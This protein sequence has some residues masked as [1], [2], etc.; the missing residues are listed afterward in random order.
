MGRGLSDLQKCIL[1]ILYKR[2]EVEP[3]IN[4]GVE[5]PTYLVW[6]NFHVQKDYFKF[7]VKPGT[8]RFE[9]PIDNNAAKAA[10]CR[11]M[12]RLKERGLIS[13][14]ERAVELT[15]AGMKVAREIYLSAEQDESKG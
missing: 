13:Q 10:T 8:W 6:I 9:E 7:P 1:K 11:A 5:M 2:K 12:A 4:R 15:D 3:I 14:S